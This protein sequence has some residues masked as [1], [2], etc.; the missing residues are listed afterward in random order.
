[1][2]YRKI[3]F[4]FI[5]LWLGSTPQQTKPTAHIAIEVHDPTG[6][7]IP[8]AHVEVSVSATDVKKLYADD[9]GKLSVDLPAGTYE[10]T[11]TYPAFTPAK[12]RIDVQDARNQIVIFMLDV[13]VSGP[14]VEVLDVPRFSGPMPMP[15]TKDP[16]KPFYEVTI[17]T[18][19]RATV[20]SEVK[21]HIITKNISDKAIYLVRPP[22]RGLEI[23]VRDSQGNP[24]QESTN[25]SRFWSMPFIISSENAFTQ[26]YPIQP[27]DRVEEDLNVSAEYEFSKPGTYSIQVLRSDILTEEEINAHLSPQAVKSNTA[28]L[29]LVP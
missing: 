15:S 24:V 28:T 9:N 17:T 13:A 12:K 19:Q 2:L 20:R 3:P 8:K 29:T 7:P 14:N 26:R 27:G 6:A 5:V 23:S 10:V 11:A 25:D 21:L 4:L 1:M 18:S 16:E 22:G